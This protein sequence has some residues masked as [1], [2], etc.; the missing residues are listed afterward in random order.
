MLLSIRQVRERPRTP[1][2][3]A[4]HLSVLMIG[5][6]V[7]HTYFNTK[8]VK[9]NYTSS[10]RR[11]LSEVCSIMLAPLTLLFA[12]F[13]PNIGSWADYDFISD[14]IHY[15]IN[16]DNKSVSVVSR[17]WKYSGDVVIPSTVVHEDKT[18]RVTGIGEDA[19]YACSITSIDLPESLTSIEKGA[20]FR[21]SD[22]TTFIC[23]S[24]DLSVYQTNGTRFFF[25]VPLCDATLYVPESVLKYCKEKYDWR[26]F[27]NKL[28][29]E[30]YETGTDAPASSQ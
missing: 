14:D 24:E 18:Y 21:C 4:T 10:L 5:T 28:P 6:I 1:R 30:D 17:I 23:R 25:R 26:D 8:Q 27:R 19:F 20:F 9:Q 12:L 2:W 11:T 22:L 29:L 3:S 7:I 13:M 15:S 16:A